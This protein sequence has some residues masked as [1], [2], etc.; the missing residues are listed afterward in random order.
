MFFASLIDREFG[1]NR[2]QKIAEKVHDFQNITP[3]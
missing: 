2:L 3:L 1:L